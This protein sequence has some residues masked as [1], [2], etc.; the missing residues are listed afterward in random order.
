MKE[1]GIFTSLNAKTG[2]PYLQTRLT[3]ALGQYG[4]SPVAADGKIYVAN[5]EGKVSVIRAAAEWEVLA[6]NEMNDEIFA[7]PAIADGNIYLRTRTALYR[8]GS[9]S[10]RK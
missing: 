4:S 7:T 3:G 5:E 8:F 10:K 1:G 6:V 2:E 9:P